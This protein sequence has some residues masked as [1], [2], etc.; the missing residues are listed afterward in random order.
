LEVNM[1]KGCEKYPQD[2]Y[3]KNDGAGGVKTPTAPKAVSGSEKTKTGR[4]GK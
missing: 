4:A 2:K 1:A 3:A